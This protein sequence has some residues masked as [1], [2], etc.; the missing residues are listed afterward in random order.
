MPWRYNQQNPK[1]GK[2]LN[3]EL[4]ALIINCNKIK[5]D[6]DRGQENLQ[7]KKK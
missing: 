3:K 5:L 1:C 2:L 6:R 7:P 4:I